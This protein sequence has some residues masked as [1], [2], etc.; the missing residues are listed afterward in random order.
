[1]LGGSYLDRHCPHWY[2]TDMSLYRLQNRDAKC[3]MDTL[4][5]RRLPRKKSYRHCLNTMAF[6]CFAPIRALD[7]L[8]ISRF[9]HFLVKS[10][11]VRDRSEAQ[12]E[13]ERTFASESNLRREARAQATMEDANLKWTMSMAFFALSGGCVCRIRTGEYRIL[14][15]P[16]IVD[17]VR[18]EPLS[19]LPVQRLVLQDP[20]KANEIAKLIACIQ[21]FW[22]CS[23]CI[24]RLGANQA[25]SLLELNTFAHCISTLLIYICWWNKPYNAEVHAVI[26]SPW[27]DLHFLMLPLSSC[28]PPAV[29]S[30][31][32]QN[33]LPN[34]S[35]MTGLIV[36]INENVLLRI[37]EWTT[38]IGTN[39]TEYR[40]LLPGAPSTNSRLRVKIPDTGLYLMVDVPHASIDADICLRERDLDAWR[41]FWH[42]W[43]DL[44]CPLPPNPPL[45]RFVFGCE[46]SYASDLDVNLI[47]LAIW[48][49]IRSTTA[50]VITLTSIVYGGL[51]SL[52]WQYSFSSKSERLLWQ[53]SS[54]STSSSGLILFAFFISY[55]IDPRYTSSHR[56]R[57]VYHRALHF[58]Q[59]TMYYGIKW[60]AYTMILFNLASRAFLFVE[61]FV[62]LPNSP[63]ST[64]AIPSWTSYIPH[65]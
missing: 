19:L 54:V 31:T 43:I 47:L 25:V 40:K 22:F 27:L 30:G 58:A 6:A 41:R 37:F 61:S 48:G 51:H 18:H 38:E 65:L 32:N 53:I 39:H 62:A 24:A 5:G 35:Y 23:Q 28:S 44:E 9:G 57:G 8:R 49:E 64:Y 26:T 42:A 59:Y 14:D 56:T 1:M 13:D 21:A 33:S 29:I 10:G 52:A 63:K 20:G 50:L 17:L 16:I 7:R 55:R 36:D 46:T 45:F 3:L 2:P 12:C 4:N 15:H 11:L 60:I 34:L